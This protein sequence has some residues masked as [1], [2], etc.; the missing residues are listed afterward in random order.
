MRNLAIAWDTEL[1]Q[2]QRDAWDTYASNVSWVNRL[3]QSIVLTGLQHYVRSN[4]PRLLCE[5]GR[6][7]EGP[8][9]FDIAQAEQSLACTAS[10]ATQLLSFVFDDTAAWC[11]ETGGF[12]IFYMGIPQ[13]ASR[14]FFGGPWRHVGCQLGQDTPNGEPASP[15]AI[16]GAWPFAEGQR[17][18]V[19]TRIGRADGRLSEFAQVNFLAAA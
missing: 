9:I 18:W 12:E 11:S 13:N 3:G 8:T 16:A 5:V 15:Y 19:R 4:V 14:K 17:I 1:T 10:E 2:D 6:V 7:D